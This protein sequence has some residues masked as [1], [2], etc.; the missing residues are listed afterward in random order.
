M[1]DHQAQLDR[2]EQLLRE[3]NQLRS[4]AI[5]LQQEAIATQKSLIE[6]QRAQLA[7]AS[8]INDGA[9][10]VQQRARKLLAIVIP[11]LV[12]LIVYVSYLLFVRPYV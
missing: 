1:S 11:V 7:K 10:A 2:I 4:Q 9:L 8:Q 6:E 5:A 12:V 3:G